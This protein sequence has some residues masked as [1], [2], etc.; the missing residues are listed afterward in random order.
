MNLKMF[1]KHHSFNLKSWLVYNIWYG[2]RHL[3]NILTE[4]LLPN[5]I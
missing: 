3:N 2:Y 5:N 1:H 4:D